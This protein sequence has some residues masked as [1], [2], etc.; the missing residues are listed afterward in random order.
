[1]A[2]AGEIIKKIGNKH[3]RTDLPVL[4][5]GDTI[6]MRL[7]VKEADKMRVH[8]YEG[9]VIRKNGGGVGATFTIRKI[10]YGEGVERTFPVHS[11]LIESISV[12]SKGKV[13]RARLYYLRDR[14]GK[15]AKVKKDLSK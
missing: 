12:V 9:T 10:S 2:A 1:M 14:V 13:N 5:I 3:L 11:P 7:K 15:K 6:K 8:P 4:E